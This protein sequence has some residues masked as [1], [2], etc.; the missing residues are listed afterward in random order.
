M[1][2][3]SNAVLEGDSV[4]VTVKNNELLIE[5]KKGKIKSPIRMRS[6]SSSKA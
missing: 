2:I 5:T 4:L 6:N 3:I 1:H